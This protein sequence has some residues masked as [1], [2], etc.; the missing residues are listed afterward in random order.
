MIA[1]DKWHADDI[2]P[3]VIVPFANDVSDPAI[4]AA[5]KLNLE[6][7]GIKPRFERM[8]GTLTSMFTYDNLI[9]RLWEEGEP[10]ILV[11]HDILPWPGA[12]QQLWTCERPW[13]GFEYFIFGEMRVQ[14]GC[15]KFE[16]ARL[17]PVPLPDD[18]VMAWPG[19]DWAIIAA[20]ARR[21]ESG[22]LHTPPVTHLNPAHQRRTTSVVLRP[23]AVPA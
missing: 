4:L 7:Q 13:C 5:T 19:M 2:Q 15:V 9:R 16:P 18:E 11:E 3:R 8:N 21:G 23:E 17:G 6:M 14:L 1:S 12:V 22:H 10:F 20:L